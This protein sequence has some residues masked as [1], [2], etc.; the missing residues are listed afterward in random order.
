LEKI[1]G[2]STSAN[3]GALL[4]YKQLFFR[5]GEKKDEH[6]RLCSDILI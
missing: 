5:E 2:A 1:I 6:Q 3:Y 4:K